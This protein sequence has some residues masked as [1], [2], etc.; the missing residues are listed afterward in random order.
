ML[1]YFYCTPAAAKF[2]GFC[3]MKTELNIKLTHKTELLNLFEF[4]FV[5]LLFGNPQGDHLKGEPN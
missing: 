4:M 2:P 5:H 1:E 3:K